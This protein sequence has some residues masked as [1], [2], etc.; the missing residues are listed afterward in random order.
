[1]TTTAFQYVF[2]NAESI[3]IDMQPVVAQTISRNMT[4]RSVVRASG[5]KQFVVKL[6][7]GMPYDIAKPYIAAIETA[8]KYTDGT[9]TISPSTYGTWF[10]PTASTTYTIICTSFPQWNVFARNQV[11][12]SGAFVFMEV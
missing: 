1:M 10:E 7:D 2:D 9:V 8:G 12:W 5:K 4:V 11:S 3:S 6:P